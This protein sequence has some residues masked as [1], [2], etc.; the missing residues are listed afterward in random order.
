MTVP[1]RSSRRVAL[2]KKRNDTGSPTTRPSSC[3]AGTASVPS[4]MPKGAMQRPCSGGSIPGTAGIE[5]SM[6]T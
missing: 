1:G 6:P 3:G 2:S 4:S 5:L